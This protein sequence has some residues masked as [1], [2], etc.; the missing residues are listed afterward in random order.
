MITQSNNGTGTL[1]IGSEAT[2]INIRPINPYHRKE[3][4]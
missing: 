1:Q 4:E 3:S 2:I